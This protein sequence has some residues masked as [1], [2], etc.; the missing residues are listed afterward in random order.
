MKALLIN[1]LLLIVVVPS[2][3]AQEGSGTIEGFVRDLSG[4][5]ITQATVY[6]YQVD[7]VRHRITT[8]TDSS[9]KFIFKAVPRGRYNIQTY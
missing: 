5:P 6:G 3:Q 8:T 9:G 1:L 4:N 7:N 2:V